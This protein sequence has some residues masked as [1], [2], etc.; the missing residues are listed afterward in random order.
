MTFD[1]T[2]KFSVV[3]PNYNRQE[4]VC[5]AVES[6]LNQTYPAFEIIVVDDGSKDN[7]VAELKRKFDQKINLIVQ[8]N[9]GVSTARNAGVEAATGDYICYLDSDDLWRNDKLEII[10][11]C[12]QQ[13]PNAGLVFHDFAKHDVR[14][15]DAP[16]QTTNTDVFPYIFSYASKAELPDTWL[17]SG[18][19]LVELLLRGYAFYPSA[20]TIKAN[21]HQQY[22]WDPGVLKS[23]DF[24]FVL[25]VSLKYSFVYVHENLATIRVHGDNKSD[26]YITKNRIV[27]Q[28]MIFVRDLYRHGLPKSTFNE[29]IYPKYFRTGISYLKKGHFLLGLEYVLI[30]LSSISTYYKFTARFRRLLPQRKQL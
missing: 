14:T 22:R 24:N 13:N 11:R 18:S 21:V 16:Y 8:Q 15:S 23:E 9:A 20:F 10:A 29:Y 17:L 30:G 4:M 28:T 7:S 2:L 25:K 6:V 3:I 1:S 26:D 12:I 5:D 27:L 19:G